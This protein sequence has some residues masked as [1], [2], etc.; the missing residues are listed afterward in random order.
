MVI[1][2]MHVKDMKNYKR[3]RERER[4]LNMNK[5]AVNLQ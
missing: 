5:P 2:N 1:R 3:E 4:R